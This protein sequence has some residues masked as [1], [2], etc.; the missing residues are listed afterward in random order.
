MQSLSSKKLSARQAMERAIEVAEKGQGFV[1]PNP[2]VGCVILDK[3]NRFLSCGFYERYGSIHAEISALNKI[4]DKSCLKEAHLFV[5]LEPCAHFGQNP[6]CVESL[7]KYPLASVTYGREDPNPE[8]KGRGIKKLQQKGIKVKRSDFCQKAL[9]RLYEAFAL[10]MEKG[11]TFFALKTACSLDGVLALNH[12][13]SQWIT[14]KEARDF[15]FYLRV[16]FS[17]VLVGVG[18][19][20]EDNPQ[21]NGR[22]KGFEG[23]NN[24]VCVLDPEGRVWDLILKSRL[25]SVRPAENIFVISRKSAHKNRYPFRIL[26]AKWNS[27]LSQFDL[28]S[29]SRQLYQEEGLSSVLVEGGAGVFSSF[30]RQNQA[31]RLYQFISPCLIGSRKGKTVTESFGIKSLSEKKFL[32]HSE[33]SRFGE[34]ILITGVLPAN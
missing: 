33:I 28:K 4:K 19:F 17:T 7:I 5:T 31:R 30:L 11:Q 16:C 2:P 3:E 32:T 8:T 34:D 12:G 20:L 10:N 21:L 27:D 14:G 9:R 29:L 6:P 25:A 23:L 18:T 26:K 22:K 13:E 1:L 24:K 15:V